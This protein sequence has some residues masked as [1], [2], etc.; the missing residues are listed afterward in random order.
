MLTLQ[1]SA[2][3][4][5]STVFAGAYTMSVGHTIVGTVLTRPTAPQIPS[6]HGLLN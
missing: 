1:V 6:M 4:T 5:V 2:G 3:Q